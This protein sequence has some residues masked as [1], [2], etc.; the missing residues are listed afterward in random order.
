MP[1]PAFNAD[2][3]Q[4]VYYPDSLI[5]FALSRN[6]IFR[7]LDSGISW[8]PMYESSEDLNDIKFLDLAHGCAVGDAGLILSTTDTG[9]TWQNTHAGTRNLR[10]LALYWFRYRLGR[11]R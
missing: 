3:I 2:S 8:S 4:K 1:A 6:V 5:G 9:E 11:W 7:T 10:A